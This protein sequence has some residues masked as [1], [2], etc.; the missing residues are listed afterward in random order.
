MCLGSLAELPL[1][2]KTILIRE[3]L[4]QKDT[5]ENNND[6]KNNDYDV[7]LVLYLTSCQMQSSFFSCQCYHLLDCHLECFHRNPQHF[8]EFQPK[9]QKA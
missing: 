3:I 5:N 9:K 7:W 4:D 2:R 1:C 6:N 8:Q